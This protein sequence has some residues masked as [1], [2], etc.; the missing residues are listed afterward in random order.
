MFKVQLLHFRRKCF[1]KLYGPA[2]GG[3]K[4]SS[5]TTV[6]SYSSSSRSSSSL[7]SKFRQQSEKRMAIPTT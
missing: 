2:A 4:S 3:Q 5:S 1:Y 6:G 7:R